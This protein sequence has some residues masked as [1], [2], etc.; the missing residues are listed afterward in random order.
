MS[1]ISPI[2]LQ[3]CLS[4]ISYPSS[5]DDVVSTARDNGADDAMLEALNDLP[6]R[7]FSGPDDVSQ[8]LY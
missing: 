2:D 1:K 7:E 4:G 8:A 6:D 3:K 5:R